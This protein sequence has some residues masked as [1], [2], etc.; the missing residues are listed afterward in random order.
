MPSSWP[1]EAL[2]AQAIAARSY[3]AANIGKHGKDGYDL[4]ATTDDQV[5]SG[6]ASENENSNLAVGLTTGLVLK[7]EGKPITAFFHSTSGGATEFSENVWGKSLSYLHSVP[8]F[9]DASPHFSWTRKVS[10]D[11][12]E[13]LV[14]RDIGQLLSLSVVSRT[15]SNRVQYLLAQGASGSKLIN[16]ETLRR[17][18]KLPSTLFNVGTEPNSYVFAGRGFG[19]GLG[20]SQ[21]GAKAL[22]ERGCNAA[23]ILSY[24]YKDV[25]IDFAAAPP[26][27]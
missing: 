20:M 25:V 13:N 1:L 5:Y 11:D 27:I 3:A 24:Y 10:V 26:G 21:Y 23:Q 14:G 12:I 6:V 15:G 16:S 22:A 4:R 8:D 19:H 7:Q 2:K 18:L 9:D 17:G